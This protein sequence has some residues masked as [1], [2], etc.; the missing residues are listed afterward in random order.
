MQIALSE[1][2]MAPLKA[3]MSDGRGTYPDQRDGLLQVNRDTSMSVF[4]ERGGRVPPGG[5]LV[6]VY[7]PDHGR[8]FG[9]SQLRG[10]LG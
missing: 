2:P 3:F 9:V 4:R 6:I 8:G 7:S 5:Y 10:Q 1:S